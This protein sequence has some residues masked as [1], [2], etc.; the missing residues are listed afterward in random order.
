VKLDE[1]TIVEL[2]IAAN[3]YMLFS[4]QE[5]CEAFVEQVREIKAL[6][7]FFDQSYHPPSRAYHMRMPHIY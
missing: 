5:Q 4:L 7:I 2:L 1:E 3:H 6:L